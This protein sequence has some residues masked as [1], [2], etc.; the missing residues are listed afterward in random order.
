VILLRLSKTPL[1]ERPINQG[2]PTNKIL[3]FV[4]GSSGLHSVLLTEGSI[5]RDLGV[6]LLITVGSTLIYPIVGGPDQLSITAAYTGISRLKRNKH[7]CALY[8]VFHEPTHYH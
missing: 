7:P 2:T 6:T 8:I 1:H 4:V 5:P 3:K